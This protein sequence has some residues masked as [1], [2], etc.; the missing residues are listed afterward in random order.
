M[1]DNVVTVEVTATV[2]DAIA[3]M[4]DSDIRHEPIVDGREI[5]G[6]VSERDLQAFAPGIPLREPEGGNAV[7]EEA[8]GDPVL[9]VPITSV[10]STTLQTVTAEDDLDDAVDLMLEHRIGA[11]PVVDPGTNELVGIVSTIDALR[12]MRGHAAGAR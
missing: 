6:I 5:I 4:H 3:A 8:A 1:T 7:L 2:R 10:M 11:V 12:V 9:D